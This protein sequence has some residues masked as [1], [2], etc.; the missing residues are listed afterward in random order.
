MDLLADR[1]PGSAWETAAGPPERCNPVQEFRPDPLHTSPQTIQSDAAS[2][3]LSAS[4]Y[5]HWDGRQPFAHAHAGRR[6]GRGGR[7]RRAQHPE[8]RFFQ[9]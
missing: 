5:A 9:V 8:G 1:P 3:K 4:V 6:G 7:S 2:G